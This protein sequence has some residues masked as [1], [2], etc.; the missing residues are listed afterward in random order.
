MA[1]VKAEAERCFAAFAIVLATALG[2]WAA[3]REGALGADPSELDRAE[4]MA[5]LMGAPWA[6]A[7]CRSIRAELALDAGDV[8]AALALADEAAAIGRSTLFARFGLCFCLPTCARVARGDGDLARAEDV[9][10][11][12]LTVLAAMP[13]P[14]AV[15]EVLELLA[16]LATDHESDAEACRLL[17]AS[18]AARAALG[19]PR[20]GREIPL[21]E[22]ARDLASARLT[23]DAFEKAWEE[24]SKLTLEEAVAYATRARGER[25]RPSIGWAGLTPT[26]LDVVQ[27][28]REG[29]SNP[30]IGERLFM[31]RSTVKTHLE[32]VFAKV[33][34]TSRSE[35]A[36]EAAARR[37]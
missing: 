10:H 16:M 18:D 13:R 28:V 37:L 27:A 35:L 34:V 24:G 25:K 1:D 14:P 36:A 8:G 19:Y 4:T 21:Y 32:H 11:E 12:A 17:A 26:E 30:Q 9:A 6:T 3:H 31:S 23:P 5:P 7:L 22:A 29:L 2:C 33:G 15:A 20:P